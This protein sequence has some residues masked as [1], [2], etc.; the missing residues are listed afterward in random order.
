MT[1]EDTYSEKRAVSLITA[2]QLRK[3]MPGLKRPT[4]EV[5]IGHLNAAMEAYAITTPQR[6]AAFL[7]Q[8]AHESGELKWWAE[9]WG[10]TDAQ[11]RYEPPNALAAKL[12]NTEPGDGKR[13]RGRGPI[14][15]T[16][17]FNYAKYSKILGLGDR[18][19]AEPEL[20]AM[21]EWGF[22]SAAAFWAE[23]GLN[24]LADRAHFTDITRKI[25][26]G[27]NGLAQRRA[28]WQRAKVVLGA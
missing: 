12:G 22:Q 18:L 19:L 8:V 13:F 25:N 15:I 9:L 21:P 3:I 27:L 26:G 4:A 14:Q 10:P 28:Y 6:Q 17:R 7:A 2:E 20:L 24:T 23:N 16:G 1:D 5:Y 11:R